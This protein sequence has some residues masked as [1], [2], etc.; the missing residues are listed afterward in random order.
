MRQEMQ[1]CILCA[2]RPPSLVAP[3]LTI[4]NAC[5]F[6]RAQ[7]ATFFLEATLMSGFEVHLSL[8]LAQI[9]AAAHGHWPHWQR[10]LVLF[11]LMWFTPKPIR[12]ANMLVSL[13]LF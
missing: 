12:I 2:L 13:M 8:V 10:Q 6:V 7:L 5:A 11:P 4:A 1:Y 9:Q 3:A